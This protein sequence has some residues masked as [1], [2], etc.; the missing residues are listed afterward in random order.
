M[1]SKQRARQIAKTV[2]QQEAIRQKNDYRENEKLPD[3]HNLKV[4]PNIANCWLENA[5]ELNIIAASI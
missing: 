1:T 2:L 4:G 5:R 3:G